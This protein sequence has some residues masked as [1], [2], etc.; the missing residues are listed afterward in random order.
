[1]KSLAWF[2]QP[3]CTWKSP[4]PVALFVLLAVFLPAVH[5][6]AGS[7]PA[8]DWRTIETPHFRI[9]YHQGGESMA[10]RA[11]AIAEE[12]RERCGVM[13]GM[14][15]SET[16]EMTLTDDSDWSNGW[17][18]VYP[19]NRIGLLAVP[20][21][22]DSELASYDDW[23][24][25]LVYH[26]YAHILHMGRV[27][28]IPGAVNRVLGKTILPN[29]ASPPWL[30]EGIATLV[31]TRLTGGGRIGSSRFD[32]ML[33][34]A[35]LDG[36][37]LD[38]SEL[39]VAPARIPRG[40][41]PYLYGSYF[42]DF[43]YSR[44]G[45]EA[46][47]GFIRDY[48]ARLV[49]FA[50]NLVSRRHFGRDFES[51]YQDFRSGLENRAQS[52]ARSVREKG[53]TLPRFLT[54]SGES[55]GY[56]VF[57]DAERLL[58]VRS[59]GR[60]TSGVFEL[61]L[62]T[63]NS[64]RI[65]DCRGG[66]GSLAVHRGKVFTTHA[67]WWRL[68]Y[69]HGDI[70][71]LDELSGRSLPMTRRARARDVASGPDGTLY[72]VTSEFDGVSIVALP[73]GKTDPRIVV[74]PGM[75][76]GLGDPVVM[77][78]RGL[79][80]FTAAWEGRWDLWAVP[81]SG[82]DPVRLTDDSCLDVNPAASPDGRWLIFSSDR[83]GIFDL[84]ALDPASG[85][86]RRITR[87]VGGAFR[88]AVSPDGT[89]IVYVSYGSRG[90]D[91]A[92]IDF[93]PSS[94]PIEAD[95]ASPCPRQTVGETWTISPVEGQSRPYSPFT[96]LRPRSFLPSG[97]F[98]GT[99]DARL[100]FEVSGFDA[101]GRHDFRFAFDSD[102]RTWDPSVVLGYGYHRLFTDL[103]LDMATWSGSDVARIDDMLLLV[104]NRSWLLN[105]SADLAIPRRER[106]FRVGLGYSLRWI[107]A[108]ESPRSRDP[109]SLGPYLPGNRRHAGLTIRASHSSSESHPWSI[110]P[111]R[112]LDTGI[113]LTLRHP[114]MGSNG[115]ALSL[116]GYANGYVPM[117]W[118]KGHVLA[119]LFSGAFSR[120]DAAATDSYGL[121]GF[122]Q[123]D[124]LM[125]LVN[126][127]PVTG[128]YLRGFQSL[129]FRGDTQA[130]LN[131]EYRFP[132]AW[133]HRGPGTVPLVARRLW[134]TVFA[135]AGGAWQ[136]R[137]RIGDM[138]ADAGLEVA[139]ST[140]LFL[141]LDA[142][143]RLGWAHGFGAFG[144]DVIYFLFTP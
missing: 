125:S 52:I 20:P 141:G 30:V 27:S 131:A 138:H 22:P 46:L 1:M 58:Y 102:V 92:M 50:L 130:L 111:E 24:R 115:R 3:S 40:T 112:G 88:P 134:A 10:R 81:V 89:R 116:S 16:V 70:F 53:E 19:Y 7:D 36:T 72:W 4:L 55:N 13:F 67:D 93:E 33:R 137:P 25:A 17:A 12:A 74:P 127:A 91:L 129:A 84:F 132:L 43:L 90:H 51:L 26:E 32:M 139:L 97:T 6:D 119:L 121:G 76:T 95:E 64:R 37:F 108:G 144:R 100:G 47:A 41:A 54:D 9:H 122:P 57:R 98:A 118:F 94:W 71:R 59:D 79:L 96:S 2:R 75:F 86:R 69:R 38:I 85:E 56:P 126:G 87:V 113:A 136:G 45:A 34:V 23:L 83:G 123:Q 78:G 104:P 77:P 124:L 103:R 109:A 63:G 117:P 68:V 60:S 80:V 29:G 31:E 135:D 114:Y 66:C 99:G 101:V 142:T 14:Y 49:P 128:R 133:I 42:L 140:N 120:G 8:R 65:W 5:A 44:G 28:G 143:F 62:A 73:H 11:A 105:A 106:T 82:G 21:G 107:D 39:T 15:P 18:S 35:A 61:D 110:S 48:G